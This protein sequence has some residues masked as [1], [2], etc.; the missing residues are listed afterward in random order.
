MPFCTG[1]W[2]LGMEHGKKLDGVDLDCGHVDV[3]V[4]AFVQPNEVLSVVLT[5]VPIL[6]G[7]VRRSG[8]DVMLDILAF[9]A[10]LAIFNAALERGKMLMRAFIN[11]ERR[12]QK[13]EL[14]DR[15]LKDYEEQGVEWLWPTDS[16]GH[17]AFG[18][19]QVLVLMGPDDQ[20]GDH[21]PPLDAPATRIDTQGRNALERLRMT[22][23]DHR[24]FMM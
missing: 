7:L 23:A 9:V 18:P 8:A 15:H 2:V 14:V 16:N 22:F 3:L 10:G 11:H 21:P 5:L 13:G 12:A 4:V 1:P 17:L 20:N 24:I 19:H 6:H